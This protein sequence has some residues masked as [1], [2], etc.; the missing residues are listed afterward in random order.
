MPITSE[1]KRAPVRA[2]KKSTRQYVKGLWHV[3]PRLMSSGVFSLPSKRTFRRVMLRVYAAAPALKVL[4]QRKLRPVSRMTLS[5]APGGTPR[6]RH[7]AFHFCDRSIMRRGGTAL[8][9]A[10]AAARKA[11][12]DRI[13]LCR[14]ADGRR[15]LNCPKKRLGQRPY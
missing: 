2:G 6:V 10:K 15:Y 9:R 11:P 3:M 12:V 4:R 14:L 1:S 8:Q 13:G 5:I 7:L